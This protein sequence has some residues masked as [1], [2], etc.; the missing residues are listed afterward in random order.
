ACEAANEGELRAL[1]AER[2]IDDIYKAFY[3]KKYEGDTFDSTIISVT[4]FGF[5]VMLENTCE[6]LVP[7]SELGRIMNFDESHMSLEDEYGRKFTV[8]MKLKVCLENVDTA[9]GKLT[10]SLAQEDSD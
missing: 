4:S 1:G 3:M 10:F 2:A 9:L 8:G 5:F 7:A 6:G